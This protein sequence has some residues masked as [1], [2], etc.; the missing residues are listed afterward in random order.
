[1]AVKIGIDIWGWGADH[2]AAQVI[3]VT[4]LLHFIP[5]AGTFQP[6]WFGITP[7]TK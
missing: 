1:M 4:H 6:L 3:S 7:P 2:G 5:G